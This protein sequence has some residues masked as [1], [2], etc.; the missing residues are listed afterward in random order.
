[1]RHLTEKLTDLDNEGTIACLHH[2]P[3]P[4]SL[5]LQKPEELAF[6][7]LLSASKDA[8]RLISCVFELNFIKGRNLQEIWD[9][10]ACAITS[11]QEAMQ[12]HDRS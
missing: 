7:Q 8:E 3:A 5:A 10:F 9:R 4:D 11:A 1:M 2:N 6:R 12:Q